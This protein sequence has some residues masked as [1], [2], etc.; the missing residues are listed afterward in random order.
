MRN[1]FQSRSGRKPAKGHPWA[2]VTLLGAAFGLVACGDDSSDESSRDETATVTPARAIQEIGTVEASLRT[3]QAA[4]AAGNSDEALEL[5]STAYLEHFEIVEVPLE[6]KN[7]ELNEELEE[8]I[9]E[10]LRQ[11]IRDDVPPAQVRR[12]IEEAEAG[13]QEARSELS[14]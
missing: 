6:E 2:A 10:E 9:R 8:L 1:F 11:A 7:H 5:V 14:G 3:A 13:L 4:Y 12:L